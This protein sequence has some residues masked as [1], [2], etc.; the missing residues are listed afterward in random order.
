MVLRECPNP[1]TISSVG[2]G[3]LQSCDFH[4]RF[5]QRAFL[6]EYEDTQSVVRS[7]LLRIG[8][9]PWKDYVLV[10]AQC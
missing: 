4:L 6:L 1:E 7:A 10:L 5:W 8:R 2:H 3:L 9:Q